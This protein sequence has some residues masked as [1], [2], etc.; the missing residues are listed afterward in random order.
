[1]GALTQTFPPAPGGMNVA[2]SGQEIDDTEA[3]YLQDILLDKPGLARRRGPIQRDTAFAVLPRKASGLV[4]TIN[5][6]GDDRYAALTGSNASANFTVWSADKTTTA[7]V[8]WP[9]GM[10]TSPEAGSTTAYRLVSAMPA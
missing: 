3:Q 8:A 4:S 10:P 1:M 2:Q 9:G 5:P 6:A 7:D